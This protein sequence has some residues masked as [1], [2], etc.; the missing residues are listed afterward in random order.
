MDDLKRAEEAA[1]G[2][3]LGLWTKDPARTARAVR[4][5][6]GQVCAVCGWWWWWWWWWYVCV[7]GGRRLGLGRW[8]WG[9]IVA[10]VDRAVCAWALLPVTLLPAA[11]LK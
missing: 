2:S 8:W 5:T 7:G 6:A 4:E 9:W 11:P 3:G 1:Q 10:C